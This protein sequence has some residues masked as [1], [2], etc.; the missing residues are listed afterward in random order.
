MGHSSLRDCAMSPARAILG[1]GQGWGWEDRN[2][3]M[4]RERDGEWIRNGDRDGGTETEMGTRSG[5]GMG[6]ESGWGWGWG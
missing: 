6:N 3:V 1:W 2:G 4:E 5:I